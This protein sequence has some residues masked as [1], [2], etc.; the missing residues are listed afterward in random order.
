[1]TVTQWTKSLLNFFYPNRCPSCGSFLH[2][3]QY[4][5][6]TCE[7]ALLLHQDAY[8]HFCGKTI[9]FCKYKT[10]S[11]DRAV[12]CSAYADG[13]V[14][15]VIH[16]KT[17]T[18]TNFAYYAAGILAARLRDNPTYQRV[19]C[20]MPVPMHPS[21]IRQRG[22]NQAA[23]IARELAR[24]MELPYRDD[25]LFK[26]KGRTEQH[27]LHARERTANVDSFGIHECTLTGLRI[28]LCDD[29]LTTGSTMSRCAALLKQQG[30]AAVIAA[31][32]ATTLSKH[33]NQQE[34]TK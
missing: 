24:L 8:C 31:A 1:M 9:C 16:L 21:K 10:L 15:A 11:Y 27:T 19:D 26:R 20:I 4:L 2:A 18:N 7:E 32:A 6:N 28:V 29:V 25:V 33:Q 17:S 34:E 12:V 14:K 13:A 30:A 23:L 22:Y 3:A 5:C